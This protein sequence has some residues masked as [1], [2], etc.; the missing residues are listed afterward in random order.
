MITT[1]P[2][3]FIEF[4]Y[5]KSKIL[6]T[7]FLCEYQTG[8]TTLIK[9]HYW[10][11][12]KMCLNLITLGAYKLHTAYCNNNSW[13]IFY[14]KLMLFKKML[15]ESRLENWANPCTG[16][17]SQ[18]SRP[19]WQCRQADE[20][21]TKFRY[22]CTF[23]KN[24]RSKYITTFRFKRSTSNWIYLSTHGASLIVKFMFCSLD[25]QSFDTKRL[26][27]IASD[28]LENLQIFQKWSNFQIIP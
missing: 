17:L 6:K 23:F 19:I 1:E 10:N 28:H 13:I 18:I 9:N 14:S 2:V 16:L 3:K 26:I 12:L 7:I 4:W 25:M 11:F 27:F 15:L 24:L 5:S 21:Y 8:R 22:L 20:I